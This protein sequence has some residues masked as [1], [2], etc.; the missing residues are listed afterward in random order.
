[1]KFLYP[2]AINWA[3]MK[4][5]PQILMEQFARH[6]HNCTFINSNAEVEGAVNTT[7]P[8]RPYKNL[9]LTVVPQNSNINFLDF[10][11]LFFSFPPSGLEV[12]NQKRPKFTVFDSVDEPLSGV[13]SFWNEDDAYFKSLEKA[14]L[15]TTTAKKLYKTAKKYNKNTILVPNACNYHLMSKMQPRPSEYGDRPICLYSGAIATWVDTKL[16]VETAIAY[17]DVDFFIIGA[18]MNTALRGMPKNM[19]FLGHKPYEKVAS[20]IQHADVCTIPFKTDIPETD[21]CSPIKMYEYMA[22]GNPIVSTALPETDI[23]GVYWSKNRDEYIKNIGKAF[24]D[25]PKKREKRIEFAKENTWE[26]RAETILS[27]IERLSGD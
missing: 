13:F 6:G 7:T 5:R 17:P 18:F 25:C 19:H 27:E 11:T 21:A 8:F 14:D 9:P 12:I 3:F 23:K 16:M 4:Q 2:R 15:V 10:D 1:M 20:Y 26:K 22:S 24:D